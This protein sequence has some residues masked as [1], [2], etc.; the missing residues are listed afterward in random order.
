[1]LCVAQDFY[2]KFKYLKIP[3]VILGKNT[4]VFH[5]AMSFFDILT[6]EFPQEFS[7]WIGNNF[8]LLNP[9][10]DFAKL[11][12]MYQKYHRT[13]FEIF[14]YECLTQGY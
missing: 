10:S 8:Q 2:K 13:D 9:E 5:H 14:L 1:M 6:A 12:T 7:V 11:V 3:I 4:V